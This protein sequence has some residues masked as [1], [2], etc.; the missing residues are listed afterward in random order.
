MCTPIYIKAHFIGRAF[1]FCGPTTRVCAVQ[2]MM[3]NEGPIYTV[4]QAGQGCVGA[5]ARASIDLG[6]VIL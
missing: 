4:L 1:A 3:Q 2:K 5:M 6:R